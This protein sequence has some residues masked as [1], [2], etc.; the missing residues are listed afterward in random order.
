MLSIREKFISVINNDMIVSADAIILLEGDGKNRVQTAANLYLEGLAQKIVFSGGAI[1]YNYGSFPKDEIIP[2]L[3]EIGVKGKDIIIDEKSMH[4]KA[5]ADEIVRIAKENRWMRIILVAS[6]DHQYRAYLTFL[7]TIL[8]EK[9][10]LILINAP[11]KN[12]KWF[13]DEGWRT[14]FERLDQE[15]ERIEK[16]S[17]LGH[18][19]SYEEA[20][21][22][23]QWKEQQLTRLD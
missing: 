20:I 3:I 8:D 16:Y 11:A 14:Q 7:R 22:Y 6:P 15:F 12:L 13:E 4:T 9:S 21:E 19:A 18:L 10:D 1:N 5:Q 23:Q 2:K 17:S